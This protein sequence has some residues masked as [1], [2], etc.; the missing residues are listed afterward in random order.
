MKTEE[1]I[2]VLPGLLIVIL[3]IVVSAE[4]CIT[5]KNDSTI[6][7]KLKLKSDNYFINNCV[8]LYDTLKVDLNDVN[9]LQINGKTFVRVKNGRTLSQFAELELD[10]DLKLYV[11]KDQ[12]QAGSANFYNA[13]STYFSIGDDSLHHYSLTNLLRYFPAEPASRV[14]LNKANLKRWISVGIRTY[15]F[16]PLY[17][18]IHQL[19]NEKSKLYLISIGVGVSM[20]IVPSF[21]FTPSIKKDVKEA[22][23]IFNEKQ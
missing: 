22:I 4:N 5:F 18:G 8:Y 13:T 2:T 20:L 17:L 6:C 19:M 7:C 21:T 16:I 10:G 23:S 3:C 12:F 11:K 15:S 14:Y 9:R 1:R